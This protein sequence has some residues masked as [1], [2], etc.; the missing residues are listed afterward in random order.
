MHAQ[1]W[2]SP[3]D[4]YPF[5]HVHQVGG[6]EEASLIPAA[7]QHGFDHCTCRALAL[8]PRDMDNTQSLIYVFFYAYPLQMHENGT[9]E[10]PG[11]KDWGLLS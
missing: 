1:V 7:P 6:C 4:P 3:I 2:I 11:T 8:R 5:P 10:L 9:L